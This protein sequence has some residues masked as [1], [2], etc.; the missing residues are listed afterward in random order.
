MQSNEARYYTILQIAVNENSKKVNS[1][2]ARKHFWSKTRKTF[3]ASVEEFIE[4]EN[5]KLSQNT[6]L[7]EFQDTVNE[8]EFFNGVGSSFN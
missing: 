4:T 3:E 1:L 5:F 7:F 6:V 2:K 8:F